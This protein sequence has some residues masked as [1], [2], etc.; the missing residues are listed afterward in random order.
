MKL[1]KK[2]Q[3]GVDSEARYLRKGKEVHF[4]YKKHILTDENGLPH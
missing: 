4:G 1:V 2:Q 3:A